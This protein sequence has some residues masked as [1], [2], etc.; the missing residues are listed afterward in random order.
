MSIRRRPCPFV[1]GQ[2]VA[3]KVE[4]PGLP[5]VERQAVF[6]HAFGRAYGVQFLLMPTYQRAAHVSLVDAAKVRPVV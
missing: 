1:H 5:A 3:V 4:R 6:C 2:P